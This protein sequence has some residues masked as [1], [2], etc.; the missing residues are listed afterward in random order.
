MESFIIA[1][2]T[3]IREG[4]VSYLS[5]TL[6][7]LWLAGAGLA[8]KSGRVVFS[9]GPPPKEFEEHSERWSMEVTSMERSSSRT[10][11]WAAIRMAAREGVERLIYFEDDVIACQ[12]A[13]ERMVT[14]PILNKTGL[15]TFH[16]YKEIEA[17]KPDGLYVVP[18]TGR[19]AT[20]FWGLQSV[21]FSWGGIQT[22]AKRDPFSVY[23]ELRKN[24]GDRTVEKFLNDSRYDKIQVHVPALVRHTGEHSIA[25]PG[26]P[27]VQRQSPHYRGDDFNAMTGS[28]NALTYGWGV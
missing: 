5:E 10:N 14:V 20:G 22:L 15:V 18:I 9:D 12:Q 11:L 21:V 1:V 17:G 19:Y 6:G 27:L 26:K 28:S 13:I 7:S 24:N 8:S 3:C 23:T 4:G 25:H 16:D 2:S